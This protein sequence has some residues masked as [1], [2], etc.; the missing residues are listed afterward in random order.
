MLLI[1]IILIGMFI[2]FQKNSNEKTVF[3]NTTAR[4]DL[5]TFLQ[6]KCGVSVK[7]P[8]DS[9]KEGYTRLQLVLG[10]GFQGAFVFCKNETYDKINSKMT[11]ILKS[12][13]LK[14]HESNLFK[15][16][17]LDELKG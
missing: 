11:K 17:L 2:I 13:I 5:V 9:F 3:T 12:I 6:E 15:P 10:D 7:V 4:E 8:K 16:E 14:N 1:P